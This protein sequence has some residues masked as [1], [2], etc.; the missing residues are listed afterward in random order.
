M[1]RIYLK[2]ILLITFL[3]SFGPLS[4]QGLEE[5]IRMAM[6]ASPLLSSW[7][8]EHL[9]ALEGI[10][11]KK[12]LPDPEV[13]AG[14]F[15]SPIET[16]VGPQIARITATQ[17]LPWF[18]TIAAEQN[19]A[20]AK[21]ELIYEGKGFIQDKIRLQVSTLYFK[22]TTHQ[23]NIR[24]LDEHYQLLKA[25]EKLIAKRVETGKGSSVDVLR[26]QIQIDEYL[27]RIES[28]KEFL[29]A[30]L[31][32]FNSLVGLETSSQIKVPDSLHS[33][34]WNLNFKGEY[35]S[36]LSDN[37][38]L[39]VLAAQSKVISTQIDYTGKSSKPKL[40]LG[41][42][43][44]FTGQR[45]GF[46]SGEN[47]QD[48]ILPMLNLSLPI[49]RKRNTAKVEEQQFRQKVIEAKIEN[50]SD[51]LFRK[52]VEIN[53]NFQNAHRKMISLDR[54]IQKA[55]AAK[56]ILIQ[57]YMVANS[58]ME[59]VLQMDQMILG[60]KIARNQSLKDKNQIL[61]ELDSLKNRNVEGGYDNQ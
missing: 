44:I 61:A 55:Q 1:M 6:D 5:Y 52:L 19:V 7:E 11:Q 16:R 18:G 27:N 15:V 22:I 12:G 58:K 9:A 38:E 30:S 45:A 41:I 23:V 43:Y 51:I 53:G 48:A 28:E 10:A 20:Q 29:R 59:E 42:T 2:I 14:V 47:G 36:I 56:R 26:I 3:G 57:E 31:I 37:S 25:L 60:M 34:L 49:Y 40:G 50:T 13:S 24:Y 21:A 35:N 33:P 46:T 39:S 17:K 8:N 4:A 54:Q 32:Q